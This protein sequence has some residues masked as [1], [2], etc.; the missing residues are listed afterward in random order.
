[1]Y[2]QAKPGRPT[3][4]VDADAATETATA[5]NQVGDDYLTY[6]DG[7]SQDLY[8]FDAQYGYCDRQVWQIVE[9]KLLQRRAAGAH[10]IRVLDAGC[11]PGTWL[12][13]VVTHARALGFA[14]IEARGFDVARAQ[15]Q[16]ARLLARNLSQMPEVNLAFEVGDLTERLPEANATVDL[17]L[18][19]YGVLNHLPV[20]RLAETVAELARVTAGHFITTVRAVGSTPSIFVDSLDKALR[21]RL[22]HKHERCDVQL[23]DGRR[24]SFASHLFTASELRRLFADVLEIEDLR[25]LDL[26]HSRFAP[27]SR[28]NPASLAADRRLY[29]ELAR[30]ESAYATDPNFIDRASH[31]LLVARPRHAEA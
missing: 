27:D 28:W 2:F 14:R 29:N 17:C 24:I 3:A 18:C 12:R 22:D 9:R 13:R 8:A 26:F 6:A 16:H 19:L 23:R 20:P 1:M 21:F 11:G 31:L 4:L 10:S 7:D 5:Y 15:I 25:G 30:L